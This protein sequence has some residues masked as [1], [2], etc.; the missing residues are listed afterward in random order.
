MDELFGVTAPDA[1][2]SDVERTV[3]QSGERTH[4]RGGDGDSKEGVDGVHIERV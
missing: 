1:K 4:S 2:T 3:S